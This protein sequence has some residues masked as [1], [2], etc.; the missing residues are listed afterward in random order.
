MQHKKIEYM[1]TMTAFLYSSLKIVSTL[2]IRK[3]KECMH[4][5]QQIRLNVHAN[6]FPSPWVFPLYLLWTEVKDKETWSG[7]VLRPITLW[8]IRSRNTCF[9]PL[10]IWD[11]RSC[12]R[13]K[14]LHVALALQE[15]LDL[16]ICDSTMLRELILITF[17][18]SKNSYQCYVFTFEVCTNHLLLY[19]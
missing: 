5:F 6:L 15:V 7:G 12:N 10:A 14:H 13:I 9:I 1:I 8:I 18:S 4:I 17:W 11:S 3:K 2:W 16:W 19:Q